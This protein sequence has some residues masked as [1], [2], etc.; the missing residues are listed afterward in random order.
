MAPFEEGGK[1]CTFRCSKCRGVSSEL[2]LST[3]Q[4]EG[5]IEMLKRLLCAAGR[6]R[7]RKLITFDYSAQLLA[8]WD[9]ENV[10]TGRVAA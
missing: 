1:R 4:M 10:V 6:R 7:R 8:L 5:N 3:T 2:P 9:D